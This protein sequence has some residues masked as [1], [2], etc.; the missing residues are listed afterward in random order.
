MKQLTIIATIFLPL[1][2]LTGFFGQNFGWMVSRITSLTV[3]LVLGIGLQV[4]VIA[5]LL[6]MFRQRGWLSSTGTVPPATPAAR[7]RIHRDRRWHFLQD[8]TFTD[9]D[10]LL[11]CPRT[12]RR[13]ETAD[14]PCRRP[15]TH[16]RRQPA[17]PFLR[18]R[19]PGH[20]AFFPAVGC[21]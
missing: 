10:W 2:F 17:P 14:C 6:L 5:A 20:P 4:V 1:S 21:G 13:P 9:P 11:R 8:R 18:G 7:P 3:F 16:A 12:A 15:L 19:R